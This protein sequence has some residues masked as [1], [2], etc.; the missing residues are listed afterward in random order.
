MFLFAVGRDVQRNGPVAQLA[1]YSYCFYSLSGETFS[2][3]ATYASIHTAADTEFLF[4]VG[5][6]VQRNEVFIVSVE[7]D[8]YNVF[9]FAVGRDVQRNEQLEHPGTHQ[10]GNRVSIRCRARRS[11]ELSGS[12]QWPWM[13]MFL[14]AVGRDVQR[15]L[16]S[17]Q[18][19]RDTST[20]LF[21]VGRDVQR[22]P[23]AIH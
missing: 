14:F 5:R 4:A 6:D 23:T 7:N 10:R 12:M 13:H 17:D 18:P 8:H 15:N 1:E 20:F 16:S 19:A 22:N 11:A 21:A 9:L 3:T 2:G